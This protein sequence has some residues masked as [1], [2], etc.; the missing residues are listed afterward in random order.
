MSFSIDQLLYA[1]DLDAGLDGNLRAPHVGDD[2]GRNVVFGGELLGQAIVAATRDVPEKRVKSVH[3]IFARPARTDSTLEIVTEVMHQGRNL[4][5]ASVTFVQD[6]RLCARMLVLLDVDEPDLV[7]HEAAPPAIDPPDESAAAAHSLAAPETVIVDDVDISDPDA[8]GPAT[9]QM[10][11][12]FRGT[13]TGDENLARAVLSYATDGWLI[14][15][16]MRPHLGIGQ[17]MAHREISTGVVSHA[18]VFHDAFDPNEWLLIDHKSVFAGGGRCYGSANVFTEGGR[19]VASFTQEA[20]LRR[21]P[22]GQDPRGRE[23]T[24]M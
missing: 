17:S 23:S 18:V 10:W 13:P 15:T 9:L 1:L 24:I 6:D 2:T 20:L 8:T 11:V 5:S 4:G 12:R 14:G 22:A 7:R 3:A 21:F 16:A 19:H